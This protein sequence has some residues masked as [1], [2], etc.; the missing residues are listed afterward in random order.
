MI[1]ELRSA[2]LNAYQGYVGDIIYRRTLKRIFGWISTGHGRMPRLVWCQFY[3]FGAYYS[4]YTH[5][6]LTNN[7][8]SCSERYF[9]KKK[10]Q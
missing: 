2:S 6:A 4:N 1:P 3:R 5:L 7:E 10:T 9:I 8:E